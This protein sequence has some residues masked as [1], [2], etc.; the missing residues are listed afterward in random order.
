MATSGVTTFSMTSDEL[1]NAALRKI[2]VLG[3]GQ[4]PSATQ[5]SNG[6]Q[7]L[8]AMLKTFTVK[9]MP[10]WVISEYDVTLSTSNTYTFGI[11]QAINI[12]APLKVIQAILVRDDGN[13][14]PLEVKTHYD[15][16]LLSSGG[17]GTPTAYWYEPLNQTGKLHVWPTPEA[18]HKVRVVYQRPFQDMVS[19][20]DTL[21]F[22]QWW[23]EAVI[24]GLAWRLCGDYG[25]PLA[26]RKYLGEEAKFYLDEA[27]SFGTEEGSLFIQPDWRC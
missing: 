22:P 23:H 18:E 8:N 26:D 9:G 27:T 19:G 20:T 2:A 25:I 12:P 1:V 16:N 5:L 10:L 7:A 13:T 24:F 17:S 3:D 14:T 6:T 21:D 4:A 11:G 15:F